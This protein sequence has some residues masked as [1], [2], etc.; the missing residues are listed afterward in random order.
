[1]KMTDWQHGAG[2]GE[3]A[4]GRGRR[5]AVRAHARRWS[6]R[7]SQATPRRRTST[8]IPPDGPRRARRDDASA[9]TPPR[10]T[11]ASPAPTASS[12]A[13]SSASGSPSASTCTRAT[14]ITIVSPAGAKIESGDGQLDAAR[15]SRSRSPAS[16]RPGCTS[17]TTRYVSS[18]LDAAQRVRRLGDGG[19]GIEVRTPIAWDATGG[20]ARARATRSAMPYRV[21]RLA[22]AELARSSRRS[23]SRSSAWR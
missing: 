7:G 8:G 20:G 9:S 23:S 10:A 1:M 13:R 16:S 5:R 18:S 11:F 22:A 15:S 2:E 12:A 4:A 3:A 19:D 14:S 17:T 21:D 6:T